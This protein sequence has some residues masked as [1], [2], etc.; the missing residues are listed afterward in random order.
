[1]CEDLGIPRVKELTKLSVCTRSGG[2]EPRRQS[3]RKE[4]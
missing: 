3:G 1:M 4:R 2:G